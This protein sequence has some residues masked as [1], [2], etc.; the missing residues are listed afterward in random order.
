VQVHS[1]VDHGSVVIQ[2]LQACRLID[3]G[4]VEVLDVQVHSL[5]DLVSAVEAQDV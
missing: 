1:L 5:V 2:D 3:H 4:L